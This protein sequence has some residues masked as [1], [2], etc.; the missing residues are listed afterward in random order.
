M[1]DSTPVLV[2]LEPGPNVTLIVQLALE[3][4]DDAQLLVCLNAGAPLLVMLETASLTAW[5]LV[6]VTD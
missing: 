5:L 4:N 1:T 3:A 2:P 6:K